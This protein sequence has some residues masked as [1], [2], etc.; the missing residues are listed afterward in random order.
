[1][2]GMVPVLDAAWRLGRGIS[3]LL[4]AG[5]ECLAPETKPGAGT[6]LVIGDDQDTECD[7]STGPAGFKSTDL[8]EA[9]YESE[10]VVC[11]AVVPDELGPLLAV[12]LA[13]SSASRFV[14]VITQPQHHDA[15]TAQTLKSSGRDPVLHVV[16]HDATPDKG[17]AVH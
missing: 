11:S 12:K 16:V 7:S 15:W 6:L 5:I 3:Q 14:V 9:F 10:T 17:R 8:A 13:V 1:M 4:P 2:I